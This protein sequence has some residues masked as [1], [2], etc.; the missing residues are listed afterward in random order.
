MAK[1]SVVSSFESDSID[2]LDKMVND[3]L[4]GYD[5]VADSYRMSAIWDHKDDYYLYVGTL[6]YTIDSDD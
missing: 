2:G 3:H 4:R 1:H 5:I 6:M